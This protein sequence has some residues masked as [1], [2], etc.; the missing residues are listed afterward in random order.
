M[1]YRC[2]ICNKGSEAGHA[3]SH[4]KNRTARIFKPNLQKIKVLK[5]GSKTQVKLCT[6]CIQRLKKYNNF[7]GYSYIVYK[8]QEKK[9]KQEPQ[10]VHFEEPEKEIQKDKKTKKTVEKPRKEIDI[11]SIVGSK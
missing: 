11:S 2:D 10:V 9:E 1:A 3:V 7:S 8:K 4:A 5:N 6:S